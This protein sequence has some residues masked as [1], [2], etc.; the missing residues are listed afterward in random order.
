MQRT[1]P[2]FTIPSLMIEVFV[3]SLALAFIVDLRERIRRKSALQ[4]AQAAYQTARRSRQL[5][6]SRARPMRPWTSLD[7]ATVK[8]FQSELEQARADERARKAEYD[9]LKPDRTRLFR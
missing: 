4:A 1:R 9:R 5:A 6:E 7:D 3:L 2:R 8:E